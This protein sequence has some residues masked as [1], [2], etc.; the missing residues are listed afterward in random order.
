MD[1]QICLPLLDNGLLHA[2]YLR[3]QRHDL[4]LARVC[5][6]LEVGEV[7]R[8]LVDLLFQGLKL[9]H[10]VLDL[11]AQR[12]YVGACSIILSFLLFC[13][14]NHRTDSLFKLSLE[15]DLDFTHF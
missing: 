8:G 4:G 7:C 9:L 1:A 3:L 6:H 12:L 15:F 10:K 5:V 14:L 11:V 2:R 13:L